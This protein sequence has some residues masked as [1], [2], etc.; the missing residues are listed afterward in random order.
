MARLE[1]ITGPMFAGKSDELIRLLKLARY[2]EM[3]VLVVKPKNDSR[4]E[5]EIASRKRNGNGSDFT[6]DSSFP[7]FEVESPDEIENLIETH[8][9]DILGINEAQFL[10]G[11]FQPFVKKTLECKKYRH[12]KIII[13]GLDM[14][15][16]G[17]SMGPMPYFMA[18]ADKVIKMRAVCFRCKEWP[19]TATMSYFKGGNKTDV[20]VVGDA[21]KYEARC[22]ICWSICS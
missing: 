14:T 18:L 17:E 3:Q 2:A 22:R 5:K 11:D 21:E 15:S 13:A 16:E 20:V 7:A 8:E 4:R 6:K 9:P 10:S 19:P 1:V 12:L